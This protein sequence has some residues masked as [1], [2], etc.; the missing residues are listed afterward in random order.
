MNEDTQQQPEVDENQPLRDAFLS[1]KLDG[2]A[3]KATL[4]TPYES[5]GPDMLL[6]STKKLLRLSRGEDEEDVRDSLEFQKIYGARDYLAD[7]V[8]KDPGFV[9]RNMLWKVTNKGTLK[10]AVP[11]AVFDKHISAVFNGSGLN[12]MLEGINPLEQYDLNHKV[13]RMGPGG[14]ASMDSVP[15]EARAIQHSYLGY[16]DPIRSPESMRIGVDSYLADNTRFDANGDLYQQLYNPRTGKEEW[17]SATKASKLKVAFPESMTDKSPSVPVLH[18]KNGLSYANRKEVDYVVPHSSRMFSKTTQNVPQFSGVKGMRLLMGSKMSLQ[19]LPLV[20]K[21][22]PLVSNKLADG[23]SMNTAAGDLMY[24]VKSDGYGIVDKVG[25]ND[26]TV[27]D[28]NGNRKTYELYHNFPHARKTYA[29]SVPKVKKGDMVKKGQTLATSNFTTDKGDAALGV[30]LRVGYMAWKGASHED[31][32]VISED[33]AKKLTS[34]QMYNTKFDQAKNTDVNKRKFMNIFPGKYDAKTLSGFRDDGLV[35]PGSVLD[36]GDP[37]ILAV[38]HRM[39]SPG[40]LNRRLT[41]DASVTWDHH[42]KGVVTDVAKTKDGYRVFVRTNTPA[43]EGDKVSGRVGNK[44]VISAILPTSEMPV[45]SEGRPLEVILNPVGVVSRTNSAQLGEAALGKVAAKTGKPYAVEAFSNDSIIDTAKNE[46]AKHGM[47]DTETITDPASGRKIPKV[48]TGNSYF[49]KLQHM[50]DNKMSARSLGSYTQDN[51]PGSGSKRIG[52]MEVSALVSHGVPEVLKDM[53][54]VKGQKNDEY[55]RQLKMGRT[56]TAPKDIFLYDKFK[57]Q[58]K[59]AG[60]NLYTNQQ[61]ENILA[62]TNSDVNKLTAGNEI[63]TGDTYDPKTLRPLPNGMFGEKSTGGVEGERFGYIQLDEPMLNPIVEDSV[64]RIL[65][66]TGSKFDDIVAGKV[67]YKGKVGGFALKAMLNDVNTDK[68]IRVALADIKTGSKSSKD[69]A[70]K[71]LRALMSF[72]DNGVKPQDFMLD[73]IPVLPP[74]YRPVTVGDDMNM[75]ADVNFLYKEAI[76]ARDDLRD[77]VEAGLPPET[78]TDTRHNIYNDFKAV[79]GLADPGNKELKQKNVGGLLKNIF[80]KGSPKRGQFQRRMIGASQDVSGR[81]VI[82]PNPNLK[83]NQ[84]GVPENM[85]WKMYEPFVIREMVRSGYQA[86]EAVKAV[87]ERKDVA[88]EALLK[89][90]KER[91]V[92]INRAPTLHKYNISALEPVVIKGDN[93][94]VSNFLLTP[95]NGDY[96]GDTTV[97]HVPVSPEAVKEA[98]R[99]MSPAFNLRGARDFKLLW[100]PTMDYVLGASLATKKPKPGIPRVFSNEKDAILAYKRG[101]LAVDSPIRIQGK[102]R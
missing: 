102:A 82:T 39:P 18:G 60:V 101:E 58:L 10:G 44:G 95:M 15:D 40:T 12:Q 26:I 61:G 65:D 30:N 52:A 34:Q 33:T 75:V 69:K 51:L 93:I 74:K 19:A 7:R 28:K 59:A 4:G 90:V 49:Y 16:V 21:E 50:S 35:K 73:R 24:H 64:K 91:P 70:V 22:A 8:A 11:S 46:L 85:A 84:V 43:K 17:V 47:S 37:M 42:T 96:D 94:Q 54:L 89:V 76:N 79:V 25:K 5:V 97:L 20:T 86:S 3:V 57:A 63:K 31:G 81:G 14:I 23:G 6:D 99:K 62:M 68:E 29:H 55:W 83:L 53:K 72:R 45:D 87:A 98:R 100:K 41:T 2:E 36:Y 88:H 67:P 27:L 80:G 71:K 77:G 56:P 32:V 78:L 38:K 9:A 48:F 92:M 66:L 1:S 13:T